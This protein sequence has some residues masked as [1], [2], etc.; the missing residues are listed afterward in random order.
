MQDGDPY[1]EEMEQCVAMIMSQLRARGVLN[2]H[3]LAYQS[4]VGPVWLSSAWPFCV[5]GF[6]VPGGLI[7]ASRLLRRAAGACPL[8]RACQNSVLGFRSVQKQWYRSMC[9]VMAAVVSRHGLLL[10]MFKVPVKTENNK[11]PALGA[12]ESGA[13]LG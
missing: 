1:K 4:R 9:G 11:S 5:L 6:Q 13:L 12:G 7:Q 2:H 8:S 10:V 3:T